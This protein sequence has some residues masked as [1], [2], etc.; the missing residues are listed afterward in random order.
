VSATDWV[1]AQVWPH[2]VGIWV[3]SNF[4]GGGGHNSYQE[5]RTGLLVTFL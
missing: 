5:C 3:A 1:C 4:G 2:K